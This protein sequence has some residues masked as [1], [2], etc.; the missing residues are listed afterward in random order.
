[1]KEQNNPQLSFNKEQNKP[2]LLND[3]A[4]RVC[5]NYINDNEKEEVDFDVDESFLDHMNEQ[6]YSNPSQQEVNDF[7]WAMVEECSETKE[8]DLPPIGQVMRKSRGIE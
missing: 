6:G 3:R 4:V 1:M 7:V 2:E 8:E 5:V